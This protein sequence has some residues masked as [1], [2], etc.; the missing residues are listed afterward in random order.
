MVNCPAFRTRDPVTANADR[1]SKP[2]AFLA[3]RSA[4]MH[5]GSMIDWNDI[6]YF[7]A[8]ARS[9]TTAAAARSL[10]VNQSTVVRR[11]AVLEKGLGLRLFSKKREG[12]RLTCQGEALLQ[13]AMAVEA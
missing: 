11:L 8:V 2:S 5:N 6:R 1:L 9:G 3:L 13:E 4:K 10:N 12:Y 7:L